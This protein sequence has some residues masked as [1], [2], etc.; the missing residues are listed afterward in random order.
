M[1]Q[2]ALRVEAGAE[3]DSMPRLQRKTFDRPDRSRNLGTGELRLLELD[4]A[5]IGRV[6]LP[7]G[8]HWSQDVR[9]VVGTASCQ[10]RHVAYTLSGTLHVVM[11]DGTELDIGPGDA[12]EIPPGHDAWVVGDETYVSVEWAGSRLYGA[13]S[14]E[15]GDR[16]LA[17]IMFTDIVGST[18]MLAQLGDA[19]W[20]ALVLEHDTRLRHQLDAFRGREVAM[21]GDGFLALF[22]SP[23]RAA[24][25]ALAIGPAMTDLGIN[26][27]AGLHTGEIE[28]VGGNARGLAVHTAARIAA[29]AEA[30]EVLVS[31]TTRDLLEGSGLS[32]T[33]RGSH[34]L[35]GIAGPRTLFAVLRDP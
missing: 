8:W 35:K 15:L 5:A 34:E 11:D 12:H 23:A 10:I 27:R 24:R 33:S 3:C 9:P 1:S 18:A 14:D 21:T 25:C 20:R 19:G 29:L 17:T 16:T 31:S 4:E 26:V 6:T 22:D 2:C 32:F 30:N 28:I 7:P 13:S